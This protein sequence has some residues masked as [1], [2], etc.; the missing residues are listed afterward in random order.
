MQWRRLCCVEM[1]NKVGAFGK[2]G[3]FYE[4]EV[5]MMMIV[6]YPVNRHQVRIPMQWRRL[7]CVEMANKVGAFGKAGSLL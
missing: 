7:C 5:I 2:A 6:N 3:S 1:A 4:V